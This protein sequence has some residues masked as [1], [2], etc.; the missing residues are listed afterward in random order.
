MVAVAALP[1]AVVASF[2]LLPFVTVAA[3]PPRPAWHLDTGGGD[4]VRRLSAGLSWPGWTD[5]PCERG[6]RADQWWLLRAARWW[7][8]HDPGPHHALWDLSAMP[9]LRIG[10]QATGATRGFLE[11][12]VGVHVLSDSRIGPARG[13]G[14]SLQFGETLAAGLEFGEHH[15]QALTARLEHVSNGGLKSPNNGITFFVLEYR[16]D[17]H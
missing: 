5:I 4:G 8:P 7:H 9:V 6:C 17:F 14:S 2:L 11:V 1:R 13:F 16:H 10:N 12:G 3:D 15:E